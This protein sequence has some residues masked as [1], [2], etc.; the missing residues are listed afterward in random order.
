MF[1]SG[2]PGRRVKRLAG[3]KRQR[4]ATLAVLLAAVCGLLA[5]AR[6]AAQ[7]YPIE[8][9]KAA[10]LY[11]F[12]SYVEWPDTGLGDG[13]FT[14]AVVGA[15]D[16]AREL[17]H[18][19]AA[20]RIHAREARVRML[21]GAEP[22]DGI[23]MLYVGPHG[24][25]HAAAL[26]ARAKGRPVLVVTDEQGGIPDGAVINLAV[27]DRHV[28][29]EV[30]LAAAE[31]ARLTLSAGML[32]IAM[33]VERGPPRLNSLCSDGYAGRPAIAR[34]RAPFAVAGAPRARPL[35]AGFAGGG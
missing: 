31:R 34:C 17:Q 33:R 8:S 14:I 35:R 19:V 11:R 1:A 2:P 29:F 13:D 32:S 18:I 20:H 21:T 30:S 27:V 23:Q 5:A 12:T 4:L 24:A 28:R 25:A 7:E 6:S 22:L 15:D 16:V 9:V 26:L 3:H 10:F